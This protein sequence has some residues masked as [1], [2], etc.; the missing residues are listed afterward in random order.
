ME[1][2]IINAT[3]TLPL[4][5]AVLRPGRPLAAAQFTGDKLPTTKHFGAFRDGQLLGIASI[6]LAEM[7]EHTGLAALQLR[8]MATAP[9]VRGAGFGRAL[10]V[11]CVAI[12]RE[13]GAEILWCNARIPAVGFY[14]KLSWEIIGEEFDIPDVGPHFRMWRPLTGQ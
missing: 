10:V 7:P 4:R 3:E 12:A 5:S 9:E 8:G 13:N 2:R 14:Q 6:F 1:I 11:A